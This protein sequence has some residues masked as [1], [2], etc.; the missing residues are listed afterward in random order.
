MKEQAAPKGPDS[1]RQRREE[2]SSG[3]GQQEPSSS[4][5]GPLSPRRSPRGTK[6]VEASGTLPDS[7]ATSLRP[8]KSRTKNPSTCKPPSSASGDL[9]GVGK[10][11]WE[12]G[13]VL[14]APKP[15]VSQSL[16]APL[17]P[18][19]RSSLA[20][21]AH[22][23]VGGP[24]GK[25]APSN[26]PARTSTPDSASREC[27]PRFP[28]AKGRD[29]AATRL[30]RRLLGPAI[31]GFSS[32]PADALLARREA[33]KRKKWQLPSSGTRRSLRLEAAGSKQ[34][35]ATQEPSLERTRCMGERAP[36]DY[37]E[38]SLDSAP[39]ELKRELDPY[40]AGDEGGRLPEVVD[41]EGKMMSICKRHAGAAVGGKL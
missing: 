41:K 38:P 12:A 9:P 1:F 31:E 24:S 25:K 35:L 33:L 29:E 2:A 15:N 37:R 13:R 18:T 32:R 21:K 22:Q 26:R 36:G 19:Q 5:Q 39:W 11:A 16:A 27:C 7:P 8:L 14:E 3:K 20:S 30:R 34:I 4:S 10:P 28:P 23:Q 40:G 6:R 17:Q